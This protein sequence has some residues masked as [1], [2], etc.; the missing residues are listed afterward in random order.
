MTHVQIDTTARPPRL[1][2]EVMRS[3]SSPASGRL[4]ASTPP[5]DRFLFRRAFLSRP[6]RRGW[7]LF[8]ACFACASFFHS[9]SPRIRAGL[10]SACFGRG[11]CGR[12]CFC[13]IALLCRGPSRLS[14]RPRSRRRPG[15]ASSLVGVP[16]PA[17]QHLRNSVKNDTCGSR[18]RCAECFRRCVLDTFSACFG[19]TNHR[20]LG[21]I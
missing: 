13:C 11:G 20:L 8:S 7:C 18:C 5:A 4:L 19:R 21:P 16:R 2:A 10:C 3:N 15:G 9:S 14:S 1:I 17:A 6:F 12:A